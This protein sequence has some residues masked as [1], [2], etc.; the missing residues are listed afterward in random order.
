MEVHTKAGWREEPYPR[1]QIAVLDPA[2]EKKNL[3]DTNQQLQA[4][5]IRMQE[6]LEAIESAATDPKRK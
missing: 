5:L 6:R 4:Q 1:P 2:T 3:M